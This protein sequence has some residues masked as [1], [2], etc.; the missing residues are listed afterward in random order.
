MQEE[1]LEPPKRPATLFFQ[2]R[3][4]FKDGVKG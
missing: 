2:T 4:S 3:K 1:V